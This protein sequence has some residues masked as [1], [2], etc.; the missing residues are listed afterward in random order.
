M[1]E[2]LFDLKFKDMFFVLF[3]FLRGVQLITNFFSDLS[4]INNQ[5]SDIA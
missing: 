4:M 2:N 3:I 5:H 1:S